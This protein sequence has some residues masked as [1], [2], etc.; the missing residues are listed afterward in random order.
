MFYRLDY[1][2]E[3]HAEQ[4]GAHEGGDLQRHAQTWIRRLTR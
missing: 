1:V 3:H 2:Q 4:Q